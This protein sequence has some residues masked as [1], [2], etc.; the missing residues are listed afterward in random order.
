MSIGSMNTDVLNR[1]THGVRDGGQSPFSG[2]SD[3]GELVSSLHTASH[4]ILGK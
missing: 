4:L 2:E 3:W 1:G